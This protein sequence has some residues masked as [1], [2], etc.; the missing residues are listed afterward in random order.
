V[1]IFVILLGLL[2]G[3]YAHLYKD[4]LFLLDGSPALYYSLNPDEHY[5]PDNL[6]FEITGILEVVTG[7][8]VAMTALRLYRNRSRAAHSSIGSSVKILP[9]A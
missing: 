7:G 6:F 1:V 8:L 4:I 2:H 9:D 3:G 5:P